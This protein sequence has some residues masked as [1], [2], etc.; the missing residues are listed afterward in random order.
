[1]DVAILLALILLNG[2]FA[3]SEI[4]LVA[5]RKTRLQPLAEEGDAGALAALRLH[6]GPTR[7]LSTIQIGIT[8]IGILNGIVGEAALAPVLAGWLHGRGLEGRIVDYASTAAV[9]I[10]ITYFSIV[11]ASSCP[12]AWHSS[13]P[14]RWRGTCRG[15]WSSLRG[16]RGRSWRCS[17]A[18][19][20]WCCGR[21]G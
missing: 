21:S 20:G 4:A 12:S 16:S 3:M 19:R 17:R 13:T 7:F 6:E 10:L 15:R 8:S 9:V 2:A 14:R 5:A 18:R 1:M 11:L